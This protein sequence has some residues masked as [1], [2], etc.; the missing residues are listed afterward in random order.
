MAIDK[1]SKEK[2]KRQRKKT[3][4]FKSYTGLSRRNCFSLTYSQFCVFWGISFSDIFISVSLVSCL[5]N[6]KDCLFF[7]SCKIHLVA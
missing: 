7:S 6:I 2:E 4:G 5:R 3:V 1:Q